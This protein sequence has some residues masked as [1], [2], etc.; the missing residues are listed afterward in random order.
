METDASWCKVEASAAEGEDPSTSDVVEA[1][2]AGGEASGLE[3]AAARQRDRRQT[4]R[5]AGVERIR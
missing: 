3:Q 2:E 4:R 1:S 5:T